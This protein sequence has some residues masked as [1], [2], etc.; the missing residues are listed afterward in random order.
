MI[1]EVMKSEKRDGV[2][3]NTIKAV[4]TFEKEVEQHREELTRILSPEHLAEVMK[5]VKE[6][7]GVIGR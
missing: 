5:D 6:N 3:V 2:F 4:E 7:H 1:A